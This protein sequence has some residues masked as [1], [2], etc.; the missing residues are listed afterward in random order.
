MTG[1]KLLQRTKLYFNHWRQFPYT[2]YLQ[3]PLLPQTLLILW[4]LWHPCSDKNEPCRDCFVIPYAMQFCDKVPGH[5]GM[6]TTGK[7]Y[8]II[9]Q[10]KNREQVVISRTEPDC[11]IA[12]LVARFTPAHRPN[13]LDC[14]G[15][16]CI[17]SAWWATSQW[18]KFSPGTS[19]PADNSHSFSFVYSFYPSIQWY[20]NRHIIKAIYSIYTSSVSIHK[21][22][23][24]Y[25]NPGL[26]Q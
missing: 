22:P 18:G 16:R 9:V 12:Q 19:V 13:S 21:T 14:D 3:L 2:L 15:K 7:S 23:V 4:R 1:I 10:S 25:S 8:G 17:V 6:P 11:G 20:R 24:K 26:V 5:S